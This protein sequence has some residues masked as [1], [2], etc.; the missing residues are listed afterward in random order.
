VRP[1]RYLRDP[2]FL[3]GCAAYALNRWLIK[4]HIHSG[5]FH[6]YFNDVWLIPCAL[7]P[8]LWLHRQWN[9]RTH[10]D[11]PHA[12]E[13]ILHLT[14]WSLLFEWIGPR[15]VAHTVGDPLD[16]LAYA[17]G[18]MF[19]AVWWHRERWLMRFSRA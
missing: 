17:V 12:S 8:I 9:L 3:C 14:F 1:F 2:I 11:A 5:F 19:A 15:F 18:A 6:S 16:A 7:P 4:P 10:D 13:I